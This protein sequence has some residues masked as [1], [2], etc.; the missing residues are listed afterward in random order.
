[1]IA[2]LDVNHRPK[3]TDLLRE[4]H[5]SHKPRILMALR[6]QDPLPEWITHVALVDG[7]HIHPQT[8]TAAMPSLEQ[9]SSSKS[10]QSTLKEAGGK[11]LVDMKDVNVSYH[12]RHV[13]R[14]TIC[15]SIHLRS[16]IGPEKH[17]LDN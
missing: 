12:E 6:P 17:K 7:Q 15:L 11:E 8:R 1:M 2:G 10:T 9:Q 3:L 13:R 5:E 4:L 16:N 14:F